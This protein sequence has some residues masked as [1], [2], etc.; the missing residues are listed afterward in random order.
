MNLPLIDGDDLERA[1]PGLYVM[2]LAPNV[3]HTMTM[4]KVY[5]ID[6]DDWTEGPIVRVLY[7]RV[8]EPDGRPLPKGVFDAWMRKDGRQVIKAYGPTEDE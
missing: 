8:R 2:Q 5:D 4:S 3:P 6:T 7:A 1:E